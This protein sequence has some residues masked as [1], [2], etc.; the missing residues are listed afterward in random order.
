MGD[1]SIIP[2]IITIITNYASDM[3]LNA[4]ALSDPQLPK[5]FDPNTGI[6]E[7]HGHS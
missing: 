6:L 3:F 4:L 5:L 7:G 2:V 1:K